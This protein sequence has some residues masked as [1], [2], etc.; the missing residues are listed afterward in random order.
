MMKKLMMCGML[1][2]FAISLFGKYEE[3]PCFKGKLF[4]VDL[5]GL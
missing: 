2:F 3:E 4:T 1:F 5:V